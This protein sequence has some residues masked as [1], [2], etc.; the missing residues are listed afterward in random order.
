MKKNA[1]VLAQALVG[2]DFCLAAGGTDTHMILVDLR[3]KGIT[4]AEA[5]TLLDQVGITANKNAVPFDPRG[6]KITSGL[7]LGTP[8]VT[9]RGM[10][11]A[12][13]VEIARLINDT[14]IHRESSAELARIKRQ[15]LAMCDSFPIE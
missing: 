11:S 5:E 14:L 1:A 15:V 4:G 10:G 9:S 3:N 8:T 7:R 6:P 12:E 13:M 2:H